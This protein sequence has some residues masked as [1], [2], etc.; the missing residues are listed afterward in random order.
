MQATPRFAQSTPRSGPSR[1]SINAPVSAIHT[2][3]SGAE[4]PR[5]DQDVMAEALRQSIASHRSTPVS[6]PRAAETEQ[7][8]AAEVSE[9]VLQHQ[10]LR[11]RA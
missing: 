2:P 10:L 3:R 5:F 6:T 7:A 9:P 8:A 4:T 1:G 11:T